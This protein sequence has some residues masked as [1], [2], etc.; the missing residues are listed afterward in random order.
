MKFTD[1]VFY[2]RSGGPSGVLGYHARGCWVPKSDWLLAWKHFQKGLPPAGYLKNV[3]TEIMF[4]DPSWK[5]HKVGKRIALG[6][7]LRF[8]ADHEILP[9]EESNPDKGGKRKYIRK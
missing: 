2:E 5:Q 7:C 9:L 6:R 8:F 3:D 4:D 1:M